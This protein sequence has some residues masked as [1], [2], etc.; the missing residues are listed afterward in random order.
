MAPRNHL[1]PIAQSVSVVPH[2]FVTRAVRARQRSTEW[3]SVDGVLRVLG[4]GSFKTTQGNN[5]MRFIDQYRMRASALAL[6][7]GSALLMAMASPAAA[8]SVKW[9]SV[10]GI[11]Q[12]GN[13]VAGIAGGGQP[14]STLGGDASVNLS[15]GR[16]EFE[17]RG[18]VLA[19]GDTI[20]TPGAINQVK[21]TLVCVNGSTPVAIDT[22]LVTLNAK[23]DAEFSGSVGPIPTTCTATNTVFLIRIAAN[24]WI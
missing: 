12:A 9:R 13:V 17:V 22:P 10:I 14:W 2:T 21:G 6:T 3:P 5:A 7:M 15:N 16:V 8:Q 20:G 4:L 18:L 11:M 23:G 1:H 24:R 19:G